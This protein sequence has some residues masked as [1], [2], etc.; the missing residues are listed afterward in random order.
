[1]KFFTFYIDKHSWGDTF[2]YPIAIKNNSIVGFIY[3]HESGLTSVGADTFIWLYHEELSDSFDTL[4]NWPDSDIVS[5]TKVPKKHQL[6]EFLL[7]GW[8]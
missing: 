3:D 8:R 6:I 1:M 4:N 2:H 5:G 7:E